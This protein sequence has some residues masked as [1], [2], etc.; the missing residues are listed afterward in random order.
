MADDLFCSRTLWFTPGCEGRLLARNGGCATSQGDN[1]AHN[2]QRNFFR[3]SRAQV[4]SGGRP[5]MLNLF[6]GHAFRQQIVQYQSRTMRAGHKRHVSS[7]ALKSAL[8]PKMVVLV[9]RGNHDVGAWTENNLGDIEVL[10][11]NALG[12][13]EVLAIGPRIAD[14]DG[15]VHQVGKARKGFCNASVPGDYEFR[16][17]QHRLD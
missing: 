10:V 7:F 14:Y 4:Q 8:Q 1:L 16:L 5:D 3:R 13:R 11:D 9:Q 12:V 15:E 17:R 2:A 6:R